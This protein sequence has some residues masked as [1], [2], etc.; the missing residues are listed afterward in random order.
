MENCHTAEII[1]ELSFGYLMLSPLSGVTRNPAARVSEASIF[2]TNT[3]R[4]IVSTSGKLCV[5]IFP[6]GLDLLSSTSEGEKRVRNTTRQ[7]NFFYLLPLPSL[8]DMRANLTFFRSEPFS[9]TN[10]VLSY[11]P[12]AITTSSNLTRGSTHIPGLGVGVM[13]IE[14]FFFKPGPAPESDFSSADSANIHQ[15]S[16]ASCLIPLRVFIPPA[17]S[18]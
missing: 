15:A 9:M 2:I 5:P 3:N 16:S 8:D 10:N 6:C 12:D 1:L 14:A 17:R 4:S 18:L 7:L 13:R 11:W